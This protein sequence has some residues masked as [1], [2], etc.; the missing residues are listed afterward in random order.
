M[1]VQQKA[2]MPQ[3]RTNG[4]QMLSGPE[5]SATKLGTIRPKMEAAFMMARR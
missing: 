5:M 1:D 4:P 3:K 2:M